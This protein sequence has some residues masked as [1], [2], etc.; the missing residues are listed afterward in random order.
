MIFGTPEFLFSFLPLT[1]AAWLLFRRNKAVRLIA[2]LLFYF[3]GVT[4]AGQPQQIWILL[5]SI[6]GNF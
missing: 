2:S 4:S 6:V 5:G 1:L 3:W